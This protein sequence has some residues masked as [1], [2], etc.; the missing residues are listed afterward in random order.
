MRGFEHFQEFGRIRSIA[1][2]ADPYSITFEDNG[3]MYIAISSG[4]VIAADKFRHLRDTTIYGYIKMLLMF[5][6][7][8]RQACHYHRANNN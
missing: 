4:Q 8:N 5:K 6:L 2:D 3:R 7:D 1:K